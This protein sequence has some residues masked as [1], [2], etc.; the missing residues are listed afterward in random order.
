MITYEDVPLTL[1]DT[2]SIPYTITVT[3]ATL[4]HQ[5]LHM[6]SFMFVWCIDDVLATGHN[7]AVE[8]VNSGRKSITCKENIL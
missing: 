3:I 7:K 4:S 1:L 8:M 2:A 5:I 6:E